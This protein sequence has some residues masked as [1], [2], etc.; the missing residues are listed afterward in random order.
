MTL[1]QIQRDFRAY[2]VAGS[3][4][5]EA[6]I[7]EPAR[8]GL[9]V[10]RHAY[11]ANLIACLRDS[12][13]KTAAWLGEDAFERAALAH[14]EATPPSGWTL[15]DYG[16]GFDDTLAARYPADPEIAELAWLDWRLRRAFDGPDVEVEDLASSADI[17]W[18]TVR[19]RLAPTLA[20]REIETNA[21]ALWSAMADGGAPPPAN[22]LDD[23]QALAVWRRELSPRFRTLGER[24]YRALTSAGAG[25]SFGMICAVIAEATGAAEDPAAT[26]GAMLAGWLAEQIVVG[27]EPARGGPP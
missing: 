20:V 8:R 24:E 22:L 5:I 4:A 18:E 1:E 23:R 19:F 6:S 15:G 14:I 7:A 11:R 10:Y 12:F 17:D 3:P 16:E 2:V 9:A 26:A 21:P 27:V 13:E 25:D